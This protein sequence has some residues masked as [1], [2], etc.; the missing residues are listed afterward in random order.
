MRSGRARDRQL[1]VRLLQERQVFNIRAAGVVQRYRYQDMAFRVFRND[2]LQK[3]RAAYELAANRY[4]DLALAEAHEL[5]IV[6]RDLKPENI[7]VINSKDCS[8]EIKVKVLDFGISKVRNADTALTRPGE[9]ILAVF[10]GT[11]TT[12]A[13]KENADRSVRYFTVNGKTDGGTVVIVTHDPRAVKYVDE[14]V[15]L[16]KGVLTGSEPGGG[17]PCR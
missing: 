14:V 16:D 12:V 10:E 3:Y 1:A 8:E 17:T 9:E 6:H 7:F 2:A 11:E 4:R 13:V 5:G 15:H